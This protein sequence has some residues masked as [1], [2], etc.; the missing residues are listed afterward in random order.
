MLERFQHILVTTDFSEAGDRAIPH[1]FRMAAD[2]HAE[3]ILCHVIE[4]LIVPNPLY[5][6]YYP[7]ELL[8]PDVL[9][10]A[11]ED[12][13]AALEERVPREEPLA[14]VRY[15]CVIGQ[16]TPV[17]EIIRIAQ[18]EGVDLIVIATHGHTGLKHLLMG[19]VAERVIRHARCPVLVVR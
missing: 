4:P 12:A 14:Q 13:R 5:A 16:G 15:R 2:H 10:R 6:Q 8:S 9:A 18:E 3:V 1:A 17:E 11:Q 7:G 19:S